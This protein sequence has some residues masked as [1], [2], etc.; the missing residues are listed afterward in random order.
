MRVCFGTGLET[1]AYHGLLDSEGF[2]CLRGDSDYCFRALQ[3]GDVQ[4]SLINAS[5]ILSSQLFDTLSFGTLVQTPHR[6]ISLLLPSTLTTDSPL[7]IQKNLDIDLELFRVGLSELD[8]SLAF[9]RYFIVSRDEFQCLDLL[10]SAAVLLESDL[11]TSFERDDFF[12][13]SISKEWESLELPWSLR[14]WAVPQTCSLQDSELLQ[15]SLERSIANAKLFAREWADAAAL[16]REQI[17]TNFDASTHFKFDMRE[18]PLGEWFRREVGM[19]KSSIASGFPSRR[20]QNAEDILEQVSQGNRLSTAQAVILAEKARFSD[21]ALAASLVSSYRNEQDEIPLVLTRRIS[22]LRQEN[23]KAKNRRSFSSNAPRGY[24][25]TDQELLE[26]VSEA[27]QEG[28]ES[29]ELVGLYHPELDLQSYLQ[30]IQTLCSMSGVSLHA[31]S[32][33]QVNS[34]ADAEKLPLRTILQRLYDSGLRGLRGEND[35]ESEYYSCMS[36]FSF[37]QNSAAQLQVHEISALIGISTKASLYYSVDSNWTDWLCALEKFRTLQDRIEIFPWFSPLPE[38]RPTAYA[39]GSVSDPAETY[40][41]TIAVSRLYLDNFEYVC[42][43][44][45]AVGLNMGLLAL[46]FGASALGEVF[47]AAEGREALE[48]AYQATRRCI[49]QHLNAHGYQPIDTSL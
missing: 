45:N 8:T 40:L 15:F 3:E 39:G 49:P 36:D 37:Y 24:R 47:L 44:V 46:D 11:A 28:G 32:P 16:D 31:F 4:A 18:L 42:S 48:N 26:L 41:R 23:S 6:D 29:V 43:S 1:S 25:R 20:R 35:G 22:C 5:A 27:Q 2:S 17:E 9:S 14:C 21:L 19:G 30:T 33:E 34:L 10:P 13:L 12:H 7:I 38:E